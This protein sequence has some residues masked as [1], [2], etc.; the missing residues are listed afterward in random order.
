VSQFAETEDRE[1]FFK[2][3]DNGTETIDLVG[4]LIKLTN[5]DQKGLL[6]A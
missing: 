4:H 2:A 5:G 6:S 1:M 3:L